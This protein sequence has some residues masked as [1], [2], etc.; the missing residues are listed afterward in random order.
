MVPW[1]GSWGVLTQV[2]AGKVRETAGIVDNFLWVSA[3]ICGEM[4][5]ETGSNNGFAGWE[6]GGIVV[7]RRWLLGVIFGAFRLRWRRVRCGKTAGG[8]GNIFI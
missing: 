3:G 1:G 8:V 7:W 6:L 4:R 2:K 5:L